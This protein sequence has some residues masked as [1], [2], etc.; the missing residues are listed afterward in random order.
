MAAARRAF[1]EHDYDGTTV[2]AVAA[3][4]GV[5]RADV[6]DVVGDK[7]QLLGAVV[8]Q[9]A[10]ELVELAE[11]AFG[12]G[13]RATDRDLE[14]MIRDEVRWFVST[15]AAD[16]TIAAIVRLS[17]R[18]SGGADDPGAR[19]RRALE[20]RIARLHTDRAESA[21]QARAASARLLAGVVLAVLEGVI[22]QLAHEPWD[23]DAVAD[24]VAEFVV[25][26]YLR[27]ELG[28]A[29]ERFERDH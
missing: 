14:E 19:A 16:P 7:D 6:Y 8:D 27:T 12:E 26:G 22:R 9:A 24:L 3:A 13:R 18:L 2:A 29:A 11:A 17:G 15:V 10:D 23:P 25:G 5:S 1:A 20:D 4:A 21:G 28:G